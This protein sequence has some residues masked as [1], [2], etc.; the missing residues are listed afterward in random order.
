MAF[1]LCLYGA[2]NI[3]NIEQ[4]I[5]LLRKN[6]MSPWILVGADSPPTGMQYHEQHC[7]WLP[8]RL[9]CENVAGYD[10]FESMWV[11]VARSALCLFSK[12]S[13]IS[14]PPYQKCRNFVSEDCSKCSSEDVGNRRKL[15]CFCL[16]V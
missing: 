6:G 9:G 14:T 12:L 3:Q 11:P 8:Q 1:I 16:C 5:E 15:K 13:K 7:Y 4:V 10:I 2:D